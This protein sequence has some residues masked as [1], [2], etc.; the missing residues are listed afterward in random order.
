[1]ATVNLGQVRDKITAIT[2]TGTSGNVD[3]YTVYTECSPGGAG[4]FQVTNGVSSFVFL[5]RQPQGI[6]NFCDEL[7]TAYASVSPIDR[8]KYIYYDQDQSNEIYIA[9]GG[10][11]SGSTCTIVGYDVTN[12]HPFRAFRPYQGTFSFVY[13]DDAYYT[14]SDPTWYAAGS[15]RATMFD[16]V[17]DFFSTAWGS[18]G[19]LENKGKKYVAREGSQSTPVEIWTF[20]GYSSVGGD[21]LYGYNAKGGFFSVRKLSGSNSWTLTQNSPVKWG[22]YEDLDNLAQSLDAIRIGGI[23]Y[24][25]LSV[26]T[27][28]EVAGGGGTIYRTKQCLFNYE[29]LEGNA[30]DIDLYFIDNGSIVHWA[31]AATH[32]KVYVMIDQEE[33]M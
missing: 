10:F 29:Y 17:V 24:A 25:V 15:G 27:C 14:F 22:P 2:K 33:R 7:E 16:N 12:G 11:A 32:G 6:E 4:T 13:T 31:N 28:L 20:L 18:G 9:F 3:T 21:T 19:T 5:N 30:S 23:P 26:F 1:M 8:A